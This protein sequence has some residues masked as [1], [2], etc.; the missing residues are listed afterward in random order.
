M[1]GH[2]QAVFGPPMVRPIGVE[3]HRRDSGQSAGVGDFDLLKQNNSTPNYSISSQED[4]EI[5]AK[6]TIISQI[7]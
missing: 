3:C 1:R 6:P 4:G 2:T 5:K 7:E